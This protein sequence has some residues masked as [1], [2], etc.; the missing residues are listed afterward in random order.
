MP[1]PL[2]PHGPSRTG[3]AN[4]DEARLV[5]ATAAR[6]VRLDTG[7]EAGRRVASDALGVDGV[8]ITMLL[9][10]GVVYGGSNTFTTQVDEAQYR[11]M[12]GPCVTATRTGEVVRSS[13]IGDGEQRWPG[14][15]R[16]A[17]ALTLRSVVSA[18]LLHDGAV[19]G[20]L[21]L[22]GRAA[23]G[24][25]GL[26][27]AAARRAAA[28]VEPTVRNTRLLAIAT[29]NSHVLREAGRQRME[30]ESAVRWLM[31]YYAMDVGHARI[32]LAQLARQEGVPEAEAARHVLTHAEGPQPG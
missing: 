29:S 23:D 3:P 22:Y 16:E 27:G 15:T 10:D 5:L 13:A 7:D 2:V 20:S 25:T 17:A 28:R 19:I 26:D 9:L 11:L 24:L 4:R 12:E 30:V 1:E 14:F 8:G 21:N 6:A 31:G 18:P 32:L